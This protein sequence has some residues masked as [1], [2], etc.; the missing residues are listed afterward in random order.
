MLNTERSSCPSSNAR[1]Q[2]M[3]Q[4]ARSLMAHGIA[5]NLLI[6]HRHSY[7]LVDEGECTSNCFSTSD[8]KKAI[9]ETDRLFAA[10]RLSRRGWLNRPTWPCRMQ[11]KAG[12]VYRMS[13]ISQST[14]HHFSFSCICFDRYLG[15][16]RIGSASGA[17]RQVVG[18][19]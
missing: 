18:C 12:Y 7:M 17:I 15:P 16:D 5:S 8:Q 1:D 3:V 13:Q 11:G 4:K 9:A 19:S 6:S 14:S 2:D 10:R